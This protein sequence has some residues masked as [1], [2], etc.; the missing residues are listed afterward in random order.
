MFDG[1]SNKVISFYYSKEDHVVIH[2]LKNG[3][4][5]VKVYHDVHKDL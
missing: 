3:S 4:L 5:K 1:L 2:R